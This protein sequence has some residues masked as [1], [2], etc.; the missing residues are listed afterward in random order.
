MGYGLPHRTSSFQVRKRIQIVVGVVAVLC[1]T[2]SSLLQCLLITKNLL[3]SFRR[4]RH[5]LRSLTF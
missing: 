5:F 3:A 4:F 1:T 2:T